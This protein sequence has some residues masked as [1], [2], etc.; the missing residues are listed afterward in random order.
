MVLNWKALTPANIDSELCILKSKALLQKYRQ[1]YSASL[2]FVRLLLL[3]HVEKPAT[4]GYLRL[5]RPTY[6][7]CSLE[8]TWKQWEEDSHRKLEIR[9]SKVNWKVVLSESCQENNTSCHI[10]WRTLCILF[11]TQYCNF[12]NYILSIFVWQVN[13]LW[14]HLPLA[15]RDCSFCCI[16]ASH[17]A[18][19]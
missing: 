9:E 3:F 6:C 19:F 16:N 10:S 13:I 7:V 15:I 5:M 18:L 8:C 1:K 11:L 12:E 4:G 17:L 14:I 2:P